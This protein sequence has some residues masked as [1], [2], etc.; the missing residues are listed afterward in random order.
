MPPATWTLVKTDST[1]YYELFEEPFD[2]VVE[3]I[4]AK[5]EQGRPNTKYEIFE[6]TLQRQTSLEVGVIVR[7]L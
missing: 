4:R 5:M 3:K 2:E 7:A 1:P 6:L